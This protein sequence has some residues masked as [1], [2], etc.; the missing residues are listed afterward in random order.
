ML[1]CTRTREKT[2]N[3][4][5]LRSIFL[6]SS[7]PSA[8]ILGMTVRKRAFPNFHLLMVVSTATG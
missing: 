6:P 8:N 7:F 4:F 1:V 2:H 5:M 3:T